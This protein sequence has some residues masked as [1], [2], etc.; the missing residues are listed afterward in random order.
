MEFEKER[1]GF[2]KERVGFE[3]ER[4]EAARSEFELI[5]KNTG[6]TD[7]EIRQKLI[8]GTI[9]IPG[10]TLKES[11][12]MSY[13]SYP[14][15]DK[16]L[17]PLRLKGLSPG[18]QQQ[19]RETYA[20]AVAR[21][22]REKLTEG[23]GDWWGLNRPKNALSKEILQSDYAVAD[24]FLQGRVS[25]DILVNNYLQ[26]GI[27]HNIK[28]QQSQPSIQSDSNQPFTLITR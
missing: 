10:Q 6:W 16:Q 15:Q 1:V 14:P 3:K 5:K 19:A 7:E 22:R 4:V 24:E 26:R 27:F 21:L 23:V 25:L 8:Q 17:T 11:L 2:E 9:T 13:K 28:K 12:Q 18:Q 20:Q